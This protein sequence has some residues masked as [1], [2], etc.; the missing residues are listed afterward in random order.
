MVEAPIKQIPD[1]TGPGQISWKPSELLTN[2]ERLLRLCGDELR[3]DE[4]AYQPISQSFLKV[5]SRPYR[6][7]LWEHMRAF[8][9]VPNTLRQELVGGAVILR[10]LERLSDQTL[11]GIAECSHINHR[12]LLQRSAIGRW[13]QST[14]IFSAVLAAI[15]ALKETFNIDI[16]KPIADMLKWVSGMDISLAAVAISFLVFLLLG[17]LF[18]FLLLHRLLHLV[19]GLDDLIAIAAV[20]RGMPKSER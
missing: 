15:K 5:F 8:L 11:R 2:Y 12:R 10:E 1:D 18:N 3:K 6:R 13:S 4:F 20:H 19:R 7:R 17:S 16:S 9:K 14:V